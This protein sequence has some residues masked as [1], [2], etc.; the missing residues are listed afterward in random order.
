MANSQRT[1]ELLKGDLAHVIRPG[2]MVGQHMEAVLEKAHGIMVVDTEGKEYIDVS[3]QL[4]CCNLGHGQ[5]EI[6]DAII[7]AVTTTDY[8]TLFYGWCSPLSIECGRKLAEITPGDLNHFYFTCGGSESIDS[9]IKIA[10]LFWHNK[11]KSSK[12]RIISLDTSYHGLSGISNYAT[13]LGRG[14]SKKG[15]GP[16]AIGFLH[17]PS[18]YCYRC[19]FGAKYPDCDMLCARFLKHVIESEGADSIAAFLAEPIQGSGGII[20]PP[21]EYW[22]I[23]RKICTDYNILL[24]AD[25]VMSGFA[26]TGKMFAIEHYDA[27]P[28]IMTIAKG[29]TGAYI[30]FGAVAVSDDVYEG[31]K[32]KP[33]MHGFTY[34]GHPIGCAA[35]VAA[36]DMY[37]KHKV[38]DN[39]ARVGSHI[40]QRLEAEFLPL[41]C[42]GN[43]GGKGMFQAMELV[44][45]KESKTPIDKSAKE[46]L[47]VKLR[48][49]GI[50]TRILGVN[51]NRFVICPP[52]IM[53]IEEADR[54]L[55][56]IKPLLAELKPQ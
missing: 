26:R 3:S 56:I 20:D 4:M 25:E 12:Y 47:E 54:M 21:P 51:G 42:I 34:C 16:E 8:T 19:A 17:I 15:F 39:A 35:A 1:E 43:I 48:E 31:L 18:F 27:K 5:K 41:P 45:D 49:A 40:R 52:C 14:L 22:P 6:Q 53:T 38:V 9:A 55:D 11:D 37:V 2:L 50:F 33:F 10:R 32:D 28:D 7:E 44:N 30:P 36:I 23:V 29:I 24:M 13:G 46:A